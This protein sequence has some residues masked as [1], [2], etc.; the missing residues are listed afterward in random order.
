[1]SRGHLGL[2]QGDLGLGLGHL[3][4]ELL[5]VDLVLVVALGEHGELLALCLD[6][7]CDLG[8]PSLGA[9]QLVSGRGPDRCQRR[10]RQE[11][12]GD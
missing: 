5:D 12:G 10:S 4:V 11:S 8:R 9:L 3:L 7:R 2:G 1:M 6:L